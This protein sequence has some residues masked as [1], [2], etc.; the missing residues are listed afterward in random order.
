MKPYWGTEFE[1]T[2]LKKGEDIENKIRQLA[3][4]RLDI[5]KQRMKNLLKIAIPDEALYR[6]IML[7]LGYKNNKAQFLELAMI[8]PYSE[9]RKLNDKIAIEL[10]LLHRA[11]FIDANGKLENFDFSL[12]MD[13]NVWN[14]KGVRPANQPQNR[15]KQI[16]HLLS[17]TVA[18]DGIFSFFKSRIEENYFD[19]WV[20]D[21][22]LNQK[23]ANSTVKKIMNFS[24]IGEQRKA[25]MFFNIILPFFLVIYENE[26]NEKLK[27]FLENL[28][29]YHKPLSPNSV[30]KSIM[31]RF[32][33]KNV[34][35]VRKYMGLIQL[36]HE[37]MGKVSHEEI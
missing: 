6:E 4:K 27:E 16:S 10:A 36:Y 5:K 23:I 21:F 28:Y 37:I 18:K 31:R 12:K 14:L 25:D 7:S 34:S 30:I 26:Q 22:K 20:K 33:I 29:E 35:S 3:F 11:G 15:I 24:G 2:N 9:I 17:E 1:E 13:K 19:G 8:T 32:N